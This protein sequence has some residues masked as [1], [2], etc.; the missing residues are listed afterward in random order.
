VYHYAILNKAIDAL[1]MIITLDDKDLYSKPNK[2]GITPL[3]YA[4]ILGHEE[5]IKIL[6][7]SKPK[8]NINVRD[9]KYNWTPLMYSISQN[10]PQI[11][12]LLLEAKS[13]PNVLTKTYKQTPLMLA[14]HQN[15]SK[16]VQLLLDFEADVNIKDICGE[17]AIHHASKE[18]TV[19]VI[20]QLISRSKDITEESGLGFNPIDCAIA[21]ILAPLAEHRSDENSKTAEIP[22]GY[23]E[24]Y[25]ILCSKHQP[26]ERIIAKTDEVVRVAEALTDLAAKSVKKTEK[27]RLPKNRSRFVEQESSSDE[28]S[29]VADELEKTHEFES[30]EESDMLNVGLATHL[31]KFRFPK[32]GVVDLDMSDVPD[33]KKDEKKDKK[34]KDKKGKDKGKEQE[35]DKK[36]KGKEQE[37]EKKDKGKEQEKDKKD[38]GKEQEK[39]KKK[40]KKKERRSSSS[41]EKP[42]AKSKSKKKK[43]SESEEEKK[44]ESRSSSPERKKKEKTSKRKKET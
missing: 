22:E 13:D 21:K 35:K 23:L 27:K 20:N 38:K 29:S 36:D 14:S 18:G 10:Y 12:S 17:Q 28:S 26:T 37:K 39:E 40:D 8:L 44:V 33:D 4:V 32:I 43:M 42:K 34:D 16:M 7:G 2:Q 31:P 25:K 9:N 24:S 41:S 1:Q 5:I 19:N 11:V 3:H 15:R 6:I 30:F